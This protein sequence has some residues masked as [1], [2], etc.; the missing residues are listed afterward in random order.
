MPVILI[1]GP[2][3]PPYHGVAVS[4]Q[5]I[6]D[7]PAFS[8]FRL[9][10]LNTVDRR[11]IQN[12]GRFDFSNIAL[13]L[14]H[15]ARFLW[16][17]LRWQPDLVYLPISQGM[18]G[19]LRDAAL[20]LPCRLFGVKVVAHLRGSEFRAFYA[21]SPVW[22]KELIRFTLVRVRRM[23]VLGD[24]LRSLFAGLVTDERVVAIPNGTPDFV[25]GPP[26]DK[27]P[28]RIQGLY[29]SNLRLR[30]GFMVTLAAVLKAV[31][32]FP[33][34]NFIFAGAGDWQSEMV[35]QQALALLEGQP[36]A[37]RI[38]FAGVV[39]GEVKTGLLLQSDFFVFPPIEPEGH[40]R[41]LLEAMAAG[42]PIITTAQGA[43]VETVVEGVTGF[44]VPPG[45]AE[46][47]IERIAGWMCDPEMM[48]RMGQAGRERY[49]KHYT[50]Q[51]S[52]QRLAALFTEV[53]N[54]KFNHNAIE[55]HSQCASDFDVQYKKDRSFKERIGIWEKLV[56]KYSSKEKHALDIGCGSGIFSFYL[57]E[58]TKSVVAIDA[59]AE[60][61]R[62]CR[63]KQ[64]NS[65]L[66]NIEFINYDIDA[67][68]QTLMGKADIIICSSVLEYL[69][70][71]DRSL[72]LLHS[73]LNHNG[74]LIFS[75]PNKRSFYRS[76]ESIIFRLIGL[77]RYYRYIKHICS[78]GET[79]TK[80]EAL[81]LVVLESVFYGATP[82]LSTF[83]RRLSLSEYSDN[84]FLVVAQRSR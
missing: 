57:A 27:T 34:L 31:Q 46:A 18:A 8:A 71:L 11:S 56:D 3:P 21:Q 60:M 9:I 58:R 12:I 51:I 62:I 4:T 54:E 1:I 13:A 41:V 50:E 67:L 59:S 77:P 61:L 14:Y 52:N 63:E 75:L 23:V 19:Y 33:E 29:L 25:T 45:D 76:I 80:V 84:L 28:G 49:L 79:K 44:F 5:V 81:G 53:L 68:G 66:R 36:G 65:A 6:L 30:K 78:L 74:I 22:L 38:R 43:I 20:L 55:W 72:E 16:L 26:V 2:I 10:H 48:H 83:F 32:R 70:D 42:L 15:G 73:L 69:G 37:E 7:S 24:N 17:L 35:Q 82:I 39:E 47:I 64:R 40:P